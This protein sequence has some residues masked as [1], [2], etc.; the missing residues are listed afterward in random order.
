MLFFQGGA[1]AQ[2]AAIPL[3]LALGGSDDSPP[4]ADY[5]VTGYWSQKAAQ[6]VGS[7]LMTLSV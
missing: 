2:F 7:F 4:C 6:E 3:N 5:L 1:T